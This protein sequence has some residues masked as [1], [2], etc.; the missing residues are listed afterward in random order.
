M[1]RDAGK[2]ETKNHAGCREHHDLPSSHDINI[3]QRKKREDEVRPADNES[4]RC[5]LVEPYLLEERCRVIHERIESTELLVR[6]HAA[7]DDFATSVRQDWASNGWILLSALR[8]TGTVIMELNRSKKVVEFAM[9]ILCCTDARRTWS[10]EV[11]Q[12][13]C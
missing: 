7:S 11:V 4:N 9:S 5:R 1:E 2:G 10:Y 3:L 8:F 12:T 6:L 13:I